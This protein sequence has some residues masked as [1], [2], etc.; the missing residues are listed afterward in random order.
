MKKNV[1]TWL[2]VIAAVLILAALFIGPYNNLV[3][4]EEGVKMS[5]SQVENQY[6]RRSDLIL[7]LVETVQGYAGHESATLTKVVEARAAATQVKVD[8]NTLDA[9]S[10][11]Q[12]NAAQGELSQAVSR[13]LVTVENYPDLK[14]GENFIM[15][16]SQL[17]G[18]ENRIAFARKEF[19]EKANEYNTYRR[20][21]PKNII[22]SIFGFDEKG[23]FEADN[24]EPVKVQF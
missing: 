2:I 6:Q 19:N 9:E 16:Q 5:W 17:E 22:A 24:T 3:E 11:K 4:K 20:R 1:K 10:I 18:T 12:F 14:A 7:N 21:V 23:Y 13:L 8:A 15:L